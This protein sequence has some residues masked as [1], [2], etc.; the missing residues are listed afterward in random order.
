MRGCCHGFTED[1]GSGKQCCLLLK[2]LPLSDQL[3][4]ARLVNTALM[5]GDTQAIR[6]VKSI[7]DPDDCEILS[8]GGSAV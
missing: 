5:I 8:K 7:L 3:L 4:I 6:L 2:D 1:E